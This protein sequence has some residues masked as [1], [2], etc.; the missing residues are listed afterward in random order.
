MYIGRLPVSECGR[1]V[2]GALTE[3]VME[4]RKDNDARMSQYVR[5]QPPGWHVLTRCCRRFNTTFQEQLS[6][7]REGEEK[8]LAQSAFLRVSDGSRLVLICSV[9]GSRKQL[10]TG[11]RR[12]PTP[13]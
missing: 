3:S 4:L 12:I 2:A 6:T 9:L 5:T 10:Q 7:F 13:T 1:L 8:R 11:S